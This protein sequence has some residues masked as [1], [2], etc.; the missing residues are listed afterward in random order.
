VVRQKAGGQR[1]KAGGGRYKVIS[2]SSVKTL[3]IDEAKTIIDSD[4][5]I[6]MNNHNKNYVTRTPLLKF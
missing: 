6:L 1:Q 2:F 4:Y 5:E 3:Y